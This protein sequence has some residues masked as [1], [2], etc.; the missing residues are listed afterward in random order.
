M[1]VLAT[2]FSTSS[3]VLLQMKV[4]NGGGRGWAG[5]AEPKVIFQAKTI[6]FLRPTNPPSKEDDLVQDSKHIILVYD[7]PGPWEPIKK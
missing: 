5:P 2:P 6:E 4:L 7:P 3:D 1:R